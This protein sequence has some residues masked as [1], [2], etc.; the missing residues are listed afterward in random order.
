[1]YKILVSFAV[2]AGLMAAPALADPPS[3][4]GGGKGHS[5][6]GKGKGK[7]KGHDRNE[8]HDGERRINHFR[9][10]HR[11]VVHDYYGESFRRGKCPPGLAKKNNGCMPPGQAKKWQL[12]RPLP[13]NVVY[14]NVP[15][16]LLV[17]LGQPP[18]GH[19]YIRVGGD[20]LLVTTG[21]AI[22]VDALQYLA[23]R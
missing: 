11:T 4:A 9:D 20:I 19:R 1:M 10:E 12:G 17:S 21:T 14:Y 8:A 15:Q 6:K 3:W 22:V 23:G 16:P 7:G 13:Q 18:A 5:E 2:C